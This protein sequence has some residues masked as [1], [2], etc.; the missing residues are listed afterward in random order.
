[1]KYADIFLKF[2]EKL[3]YNINLKLWLTDLLIT[4][5]GV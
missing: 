1:M 5:E 4:V 3:N 2:S